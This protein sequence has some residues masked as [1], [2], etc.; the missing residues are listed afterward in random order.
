[1]EYRVCGQRVSRNATPFL[2]W[3]IIPSPIRI[4][5]IIIIIVI[6]I[7]IEIIEVAFS[8]IEWIADSLFGDR[9]CK[10]PDKIER[11]V[12]PLCALVL[13][14]EFIKGDTGEVINQFTY[15]L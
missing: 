2:H 9:F 4:Y 6:I 3:I 7:I 5:A 8:G 10:Q 13:I 15:I 14:I 12:S 1:M 11:K